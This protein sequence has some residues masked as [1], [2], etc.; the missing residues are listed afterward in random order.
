MRA[1]ELLADR[2][3]L[4]LLELAHREAAPP[5]G[6]PDD[7]RVHELQHG[8]LAE[9]VRDDLGA[10][11]LFEEEPLE[12]VGGTDN[13]PMAERETEVGDAGVEIVDEALDHRGQLATIRLDEVV[14]G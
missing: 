9:G 12:Q 14:H 2:P 3:E 1:I 11:A 13:A 4:T 6:R 8:T 7:G 5:V 10:T